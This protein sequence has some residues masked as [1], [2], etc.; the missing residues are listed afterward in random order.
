M[1]IA[2][3]ALSLPLLFAASCSN[4]QPGDSAPNQASDGKTGQAVAAPAPSPFKVTSLGAFD[5]PWAIKV[6][7]GTGRIFMTDK[8]GKIEVIDP[9]SGNSAGVSGA[10]TDVSYGG[11]GGMADIVFAPDY[12]ASHGLY[13]SWVK[14]D[15]SGKR[16]GVVGRGTLDCP[17]MAN[18][19]IHGL[20][21]I[22]RQQPALQT[23]GQFALRM[24]FSPDGKYLFVSSGDLAK[25]DPAQDNSNNLG[26]IVRLNPDGTAASGN[27]FAGKPSPTNQIWTYGHRNPLGL[28]FDLSGQL[29]DLEHGPKGGDEINKLEPGKNYG[30]PLVSD[31]DNYD[32][33]PIPDNHTRPDLAQP[34]VN[35]TPVIAPG[36]FIFYS[37][38]L[39]PQWK[40]QAIVAGL[41]TQCLARVSLSDDTGKE[42]ARYEMGHRMRDVAEAPD[43]SLYAIEDGKGGRLLHLTPK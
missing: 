13:L 23:F 24:T 6:E 3:L 20:H 29:W 36:D 21:E 2:T 31:G 18:C 42:V 14:A 40:G 10:P 34:A 37:G 27:P 26:T 12:Q 9:A 38:K 11:Q 41:K 19:A 32:G 25:G 39:W 15:S 35:W 7:P 33:T 4:A 28:K 43:G 30:W 5:E 16:Y 17:T 1:R 22:W 8:P